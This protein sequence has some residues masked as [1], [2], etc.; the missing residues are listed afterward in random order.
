MHFFFSE[1]FHSMFID[2]DHSLPGCQN[3][4]IIGKS[5]PE[6]HK[7]D[8]MMLFQFKCPADFNKSVT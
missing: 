1:L 5:L 4:R 7:D 3:R 8:L 2:L 6:C